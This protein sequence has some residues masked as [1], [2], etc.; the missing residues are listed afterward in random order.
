MT[1]RPL[2]ACALSVLAGCTPT[3]VADAPRALPSPSPDASATPTVEPEAA[4]DPSRV[5]ADVRALAG[6]IGPREAT[7]GAFAR[8]AVLVE[9][10]LRALGYDVR[11]QPFAVPTGVSWGVSV[12][13]GRSRNVIAEPPSF[14][15]RAPW[16]VVGAHLDTVPQAPGANDDA[17]GVGMML[18]LARLAGTRAPATQVVFVAFGAEE[19]RGGGDDD[20]HYGSRAFVERLGASGEGLVGAVSLDRVGI[21]DEVRVC[22]GGLGPRVLARAFLARARALGIEADS[23]ENRASDHWPFEKAGF[24]GV[25]LLGADDPAYHTARDLPNVVERAQIARIGRLA[26]VTIRSFTSS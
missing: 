1:V 19:P 20:H 23:C 11:R 22:T 21:G 2:V 12:P 10:R 3:V 14:D 25:R 24:A 15:P 9:D 26:W 4:F 16:V 5:L 17:S 6:G 13:A 7:T 8:A 18:E